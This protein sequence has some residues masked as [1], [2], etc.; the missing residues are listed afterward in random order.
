MKVWI[1]A[2][3]SITK[4]AQVHVELTMVNHLVSRS[5][6]TKKVLNFCSLESLANTLKYSIIVYNLVKSKI[7]Q[8]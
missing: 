4:K 8:S 3:S 6:K 1:E 2:R 7:D 5:E